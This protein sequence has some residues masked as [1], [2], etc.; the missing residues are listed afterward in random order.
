MFHKLKE[1]W[2]E[3]Q[4][5]KKQLETGISGYCSCCGAAN[6]INIG[7]DHD[8]ECM[9]YSSDGPEPGSTDVEK[10]EDNTRSK[11]G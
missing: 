4:S 2:L 5:L 7:Q 1:L 10:N 8:T 3:N 9:W 6:Y 11:L